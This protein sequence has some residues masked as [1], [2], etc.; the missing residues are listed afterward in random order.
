M[1]LE[2]AT[3]SKQLMFSLENWLHSII[4]EKTTQRDGKLALHLYFNQ[5]HN[6]LLRAN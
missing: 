3:L 2:A 6:S 4:I 5:A 1:S